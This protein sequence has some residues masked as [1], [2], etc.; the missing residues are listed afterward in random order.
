M[1]KT[2]RDPEVAGEQ[3]NCWEILN[4]DDE[5]LFWLC[6]FWH[7]KNP[8]DSLLEVFLKYILKVIFGTKSLCVLE[9]VV[10]LVA[11][12]NPWILL[13]MKLPMVPK[14]DENGSP[15]Q[16][17]YLGFLQSPQLFLSGYF[18]S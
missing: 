15:V 14:L 12:W 7:N 4:E 6:E 8:M 1:L 13:Q 9:L 16:T 18:L 2:V 11:R 10:A 17:T 3:E 5:I